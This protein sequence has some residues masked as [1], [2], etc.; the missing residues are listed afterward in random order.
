[1]PQKIFNFVLGFVIFL[2]ISAVGYVT[3]TNF[4]DKSEMHKH[5]KETQLFVVGNQGFRERVYDCNSSTVEIK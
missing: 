4:T 5:C 2:V 1:M 3:Y